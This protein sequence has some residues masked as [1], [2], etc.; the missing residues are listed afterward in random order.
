LCLYCPGPYWPRT[1]RIL[2]AA[3]LGTQIVATLIAVYGLFMT[4][5]GWGWAAFVWGYALVWFLVN[6]RVKLLAYRIFDP[7]GANPKSQAKPA[8]PVSKAN[9]ITPPDLTPPLAC[10]VNTP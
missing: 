9:V 8:G 4:P 10:G 3:V 2:W 6:D 1:A 5:L 7:A